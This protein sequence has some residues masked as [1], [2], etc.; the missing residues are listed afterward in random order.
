M[1]RYQ[2]LPDLLSDDFA[3]LMADIK[4]R[5]VLVPVEYDEHGEILDGHHRVRAC[6]ELGII[7]WPRVV[8][9]GLTEDGKRLHARQL[10]LARR[11]LNHAQKRAL[12]SDQ[13]RDTPE[14]SNRQIAAGLGVSPTTVTT[15]RANLEKEGMVSK[16]DTVVGKDGIKQPAR[17]PTGS[18][19]AK[20]RED[21]RPAPPPP[22]NKGPDPRRRGS[23]RVV[24]DADFQT[25]AE[26]NARDLEIERDERIALAGADGLVAE[27]D[28]L[29]KLVASLNQRISDLAEESSQFK[30]RAEMWKKRA[31]EAG[32]K[33]ADV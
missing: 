5:G 11:H 21:S 18:L 15:I 28:R 10:N 17:K 25:D 13:L 6:E 31:V 29:T 3:A 14:K 33:R 9:A 19:P 8:R 32:W 27:N 30:R 26:L 16:L 20:E 22:P 4:A 24:P 2:L 1:K 23:L 12:I 7:D